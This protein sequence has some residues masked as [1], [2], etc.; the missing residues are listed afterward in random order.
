MS[1]SVEVQDMGGKSFVL[2]GSD[3]IKHQI[4][5]IKS[6]EEGWWKSDVLDD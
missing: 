5:E 1:D 6:R 4:D 2:F 3:S